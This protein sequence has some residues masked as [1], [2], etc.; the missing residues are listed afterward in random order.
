MA[1]EDQVSIYCFTCRRSTFCFLGFSFWLAALEPGS[2]GLLVPRGIMNC[3]GNAAKNAPWVGGGG[4]G[5][6]PAMD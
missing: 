5:W 2:S 6:V 3:S 1:P 4:G